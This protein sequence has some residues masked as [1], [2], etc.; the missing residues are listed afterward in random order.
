[1]YF[2][3]TLMFLMFGLTMVLIKSADSLPC[4]SDMQ[5]ECKE[6]GK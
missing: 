4:T 1:M 5:C 2:L 6:P 3:F